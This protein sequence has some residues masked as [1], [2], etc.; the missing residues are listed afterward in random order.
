MT[1]YADILILV[2][3]I[4]DYFLLLLTAKFLQKKS[5]FWRILLSAMVGG[6]FSLYIFLPQSNFFAEIIVHILMCAALSLIAFGFENL[7]TFLR[8]VAVLF[9]V[10]F[11]YSGAMIAI[12]LIFKPRGMVIN[13]SVVY[14]DI[15]PL[16]LILFSIAGYFLVLLLRKTLKKSFSQSTYCEVTVF[17]ADKSLTLSGIADTGNSLKD[18]FGLSQ[19]FI[20]EESVID[21]LLGEEAQNPARFRKVPCSTVAGERLLDGYRIDEARVLYNNKKYDFKNPILAVSAT[22]LIDSKIIVNPENLN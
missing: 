14:F 21:V 17:C 1:V 20:T 18:V 16:F 2:N 11:A 5:R 19:I 9:C 7:K 6:F 3:F 4:V 22:P 15:S 12:W 13:N 10:N 8:Y